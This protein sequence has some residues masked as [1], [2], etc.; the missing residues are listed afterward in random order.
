M[1]G[2][3]AGGGG[4]S[5]QVQSA[6]L[7]SRGPDGDG[8]TP[9][10]L[11]LAPGE[12]IACVNAWQSASHGGRLGS[13][14]ARHPTHPPFCV[15]LCHFVSFCVILCDFVST[16]GRLGSLWARLPIHPPFCVIV[17]VLLSPFMSCVGHMAF[18]SFHVL[19]RSC[20]CP[21]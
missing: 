4:A 11:A 10:E 6:L 13:L 20:V 17:C 18:K 8:A 3:I 1:F 7:G 19:G 21:V 2:T 15:I 5:R 12:S 16:Q 14:S 9:R